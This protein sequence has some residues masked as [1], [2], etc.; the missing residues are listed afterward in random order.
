[1]KGNKK[2]PKTMLQRKIHTLKKAQ[3][4]FRFAKKNRKKL[5]KAVNGLCEVAVRIMEKKI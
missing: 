1:M 2:K 3:T 4:F 5:V